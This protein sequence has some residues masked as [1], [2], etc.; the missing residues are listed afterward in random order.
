MEEIKQ[1][2][3]LSSQVYW[4][5]VLANAKLPRINTPKAYHYNV[6]MRHIDKYMRSPDYKTLLEIGCGSS[7]WLPYFALTY[8]LKVS[9]LDYSE[10]GC[11]LAEE[12][13]KLQKI[14]YDE[15][16][17]EDLLAS[18]CTNGKKYDIIF[19][20]GVIEHFDDPGKIVTIFSSLLNSG[21]IIITLVPNLNGFMRWISKR[22][23]PDIFKMHKVISAAD[24]RRYHSVNGL[25]CISSKYVGTFTLD[26]VPLAKSNHVLIGKTGVGKFNRSLI[27][28]ANKIITKAIRVLRINLPSKTFSPYIIA[29]AKN[30]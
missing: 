4:D 1:E 3:R 19:S 14:D 30:K 2:T 20:Y 22:F 11:K 24:M 26:V 16:I 28:L 15:I 25:S 18:H 12:N 23:V 5:E 7:G 8:G 13:L 21:G 10:I 29:I 9:G 27:N 6:T 17:C